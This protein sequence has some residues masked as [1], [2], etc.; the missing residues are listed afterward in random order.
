MNPRAA[1]NSPY[2]PLMDLVHP[3][4]GGDGAAGAAGAARPSRAAEP[5]PRSQPPSGGCDDDSR[6]PGGEPDDPRLA[7]E[8]GA[9]RGVNIE[10]GSD[11]D[12]WVVPPPVPL[13]DGTKVQLYKDGEALHAAFRA[14]NSARERVCLESY[15]FAD[16]DT[17][18]A[19]GELLSAKAREGVKVY[20]LFDSFGSFPSD[21]SLF[22][23][24]ARSG[25]RIQEFHPIRPWEC[26]Y[27]W[28]PF[29]RDHRKMLVVDD[30]I[31]GL[32]GL[33]V[34]MEY[35]GSWIVKPG[36]GPCD[37]WRDNA[38]GVRGPAARLLLNSFIKTWNYA[39]HAG[40]IR[41]AEFQH[42]LDDGEFGLLA[43]VPTLNSPLRPFLC[44][45]LC[46]AR[47]SVY[48]TMAYFAPDDPLVDELCRASKRG[49][50][51]RIIV[52]GRSDVH[53]LT[54]A[55]RSFYERLMACGVEVYERQGAVLHA[56]TMVV[57]G[58][59]S[60]LGSANLDYRSIEYNLELS[61][62]IRNA[63]FGRQMQ[64]LFE[65]DVRYSTKISLKEWRRRPR[66]DR[67]VQ[68]AV[69]RA[70]YLL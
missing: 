18:R 13:S 16:D 53:L 43:S 29:N 30:E 50:R 64:D 19:F 44:K 70:R 28:R 7:K 47:Q 52:P 17:G 22:H 37:F 59:T 2:D 55:A 3:R 45:L 31:G 42:K 4:F 21:R 54:L 62:V 35:A 56:K 61:A 49:A 32:G 58:H 67:F 63:I 24:M 69:S 40:R 41:S 6:M 34:G 51:V 68:W 26:R 8:A 10:P 14:I 9:S 46:A 36:Q 33:N 48:L 25:V 27:S 20:V 66:W 5:P 38:I 12:G 1:L 57:D 23:A 60:I 39:N 65:N 15:I 11:D